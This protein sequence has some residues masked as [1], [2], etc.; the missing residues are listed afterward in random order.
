LIDTSEMCA[1]INCELI[2]LV[3]YFLFESLRQ[4]KYVFAHVYI[5]Q[6]SLLVVALIM[7]SYVCS[8]IFTAYFVLYC[9]G[10]D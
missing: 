4:E 9:N 10:F 6:Y 7:Y 2:G 5:E 1:E 3:C 8:L